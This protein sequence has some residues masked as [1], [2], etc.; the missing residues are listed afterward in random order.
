MYYSEMSFMDKFR[1]I[2]EFATKNSFKDKSL[3][4]KHSKSPNSSLTLMIIFAC[5]GIYSNSLL[6]NEI[7]AFKHLKHHRQAYSE[8]F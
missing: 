7:T 8:A 6:T 1:F 2:V 4:I 5:K 3:Y